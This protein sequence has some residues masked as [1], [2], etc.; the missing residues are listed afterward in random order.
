[1][2]EKCWLH[3]KVDQW[4]AKQAE[5][6]MKAR[7]LTLSDARKEIERQNPDVMKL[8]DDLIRAEGTCVDENSFESVDAIDTF[9]CNAVEERIRQTGLPHNQACRAVTQE[10][11]PLMRRREA[12]Y[13]GDGN[14]STF[15]SELV[16]IEQD[17]ARLTEDAM[18]EHPELTRGRALVLVASEH[19]DLFRTREQLRDYLG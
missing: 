18:K 15:K 13:R 12:L 3:E 7:G 1:M 8:H 5:A 11:A 17:I 6:L 4:L 9:I 16:K 14:N 19:R 10:N 2:A